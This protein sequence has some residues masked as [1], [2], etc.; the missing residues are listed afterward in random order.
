MA[1]IWSHGGKPK[2]C[3]N[4]MFARAG[5]RAR[6][7]RS[8][9]SDFARASYRAHVERST[10]PNF[11]R[12]ANFSARAIFVFQQPARAPCRAAV[13]RLNLPEFARA[14]KSL[15]SSELVKSAI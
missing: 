5:C 2:I 3:Q 4:T 7:E 12:A 6:V 15:R 10:L 8:T 11:A 1:F 14:A 9:L 13:E